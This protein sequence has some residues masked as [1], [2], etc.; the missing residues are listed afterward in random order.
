[1]KLVEGKERNI[2]KWSFN[3]SYFFYTET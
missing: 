3:K 1:V 2:R